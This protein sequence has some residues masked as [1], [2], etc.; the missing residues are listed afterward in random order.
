MI[1]RCTILPIFHDRLQCRLDF[2]ILH[3]LCLANLIQCHEITQSH[4]PIFLLSQIIDELGSR[5][6]ARY[7]PAITAD[8]PEEIRFPC[9]RRS[10]LKEI[11]SLF[12]KG[13]KP[14]E[15][16]ELL[17]EIFIPCRIIIHRPQ[18]DIHPFFQR[19][20]FSGTAEFVQINAVGTEILIPF[21]RNLAFFLS[22]RR[23]VSQLH[24]APAFLAFQQILAAL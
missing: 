14:L 11:H 6:L 20:I 3:V 13:K 18:D 12:H 8:L 21:Q 15:H 22:L 1:I 4:D 23:L 9:T 7:Q 10:E 17:R 24:N 2:C 19:E 5:H 16:T